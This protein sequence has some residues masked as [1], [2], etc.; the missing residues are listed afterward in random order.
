M[1]YQIVEKPSFHVVGKA[2][3]VS[4]KGGEN[5]RR[6]PEF[7]QECVADGTVGRL[8]EMAS[9]SETLPSVTLGIC[10]DFSEDM[11]EFT[12]I[13]SAQSEPTP[14][15]SLKGREPDSNDPANGW[16]DKTISAATWAVFE[17]TGA[18]PD[19][20]QAVW[21]DIWSDFLPSSPYRHADGPDIEVY[22]AGDPMQ[23][24]YRFEVWVPVETK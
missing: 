24:D 1:N 3:R 9:R 20:I 15:P 2:L 19:S 13:V 10:A 8:V 17:A 18:M 7:W 23:P 4:T 11:S 21:S 22:P 5:M 6:I 14:N 12:Y 16:M